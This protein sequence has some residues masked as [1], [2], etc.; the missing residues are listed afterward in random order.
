MTRV[1]VH[2]SLASVLGRSSWCV[3]VSTPAE[4]FRAIDANCEGKLIDFMLANQL[5]EFRV[6]LSSA[7]V[8]N[9]GFDGGYNA[10]DA[11]DDVIASV[12][13]HEFGPFTNVRP[14]PQDGDDSSVLADGPDGT[15]YH[16]VA[17]MIYDEE[18]DDTVVE[19]EVEIFVY[20]GAESAAESIVT[21]ALAQARLAK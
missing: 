10:D 3:A 15:V 4:A 12:F 5:M 17:N 6:A 16:I 14:G 1:T 11:P 21:A 8:D 7:Y 9:L 18:D 13:A 2:G 19:N 20:D